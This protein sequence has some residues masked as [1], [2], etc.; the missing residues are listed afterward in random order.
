MQGKLFTQDFLR[1]G[2]QET[3]AWQRLDAGELAR[4]RARIAAIFGAFPADSQANEAVTETE[5]I[6]Q[7]LEALGWASLPQQTASGKGRQ[8]VPDV[9]LFVDAAAKQAALAERRD[10]PRYRRG[11]AIVECKRWQ[12]PLDRGDR[13]DPLDANAPSNQM[14]RYLSRAEV[15][16]ERA[17]Q[18]G[19]LT[20]GRYWRLYFQGARSRSEEFLELDLARLAGMKGLPADLL[21]LADQDAAHFLTVFYLLFG[22]AGFIPQPEDPENRAFLVIALAETRRWEARVSQDLGALVFER[23]FPRLVAAMAQHDPAASAPH[24]AEDYLDTVRRE[25][26]ILLYRLLFVLYAEDRNLLPVHDPRYHHYSLRVIRQKIAR[27]LDANAVFSA[28]AGRCYRALKDLFQIIGQGDAALGVPPYNGGPFDDR[29]HA[30]LER[31]TLPDAVVAELI[32]GLSRRPVGQERRWINY[33]DL[34]VQQLGSIYERLL[35][36]RVVG[37]GAGQIR[38]SPTI[39]A[40]KGSGSYYTHDDLVQLLIRQ[41]VGPLLAERAD[42]FEL[43]VEALARLRSPK[44]QRLR[45][46]QDHDPAAAILELKIC[47]PAMG[48][49]H[50][51]VSLVDY[52]ADQILERMADSTARVHW[53]DAAEPYVSPLARRIADIRERI[54]AS[55][56]A[57]GWTV[58]PAQLDDRHIV[59][60]MILKRVIFGVDK[61]P[62]AVEL[63]KVALWLHT[64]TVGA[65]LSF[66]DHHLR[67]G[68]ALY[69]ERI[70]KVLDELRAFGALF[71]NNELA[72]IAV[73]TA[74]M[75]QIADLTDVDIAE[76]QQSR[77]LFEQIDAELAP[78]RKL[79]DFWQAR[80]WLPAD[81]P[82]WRR[83]WAE[84]ASGRF[85]DVIDVVNAGSVVAGDSASD[86][87]GAIRELLRQTRELA[88][89]E[90]FLSWAIA[91]PTVWR[92][93]DSSQ[94]QGGFDA[95]IG[96]PPWDRMKLQEVEWFA[97][98]QPEI[99]HAVRAA[100]RKRLIGQLEKTGDG[101]WL[102]YQQA[103]NRAEIAARIA[104]DS[105]EYPLLSGG[106]LNLYALFVERAQSLV[107]AHGIVGLLTPSGIASDKGSSAFF[108]SIATTGRLAALLDFE[109]R[110]GFFPDVDSRFKFCALVFGGAK[111]TFP[112]TRCA[113][114]LHA[115]A[116]L[117]DP[118]R[119]FSL[120]AED[121]AAVNPNTGTAPIFRHRRDAEITR[122]IYGRCPVL[123]DRRTDPPRQVWPVRYLRMFDM[124]NDSHLFK[125]RDE[126]EAA[127]FYP[128]GVHRWRKAKEEYVPLYVGRM[129]HQYDH[130]AAGVEVNEASLHNP[131]LSSAVTLAEKRDISF[132]PF[133]QYWVPRDKVS[134]NYQRW[135]IGFRD[136]A[137]ATDIRTLIAAII[138][139]PST[140]NKL[141]LLLPLDSWHESYKDFAPLV[142]ANLNCYPLD[143][144][145]RQKVHSTNV[146]WYILE[147]IP[148]IP[149]EKFENS[150]GDQII[151][152]F[153]RAQVLRLS[154]TA[155]DLRPFAADLGYEGEPFV[156]DEDDRRHRLARL[157]ALF[158]HLYGLDRNDA[159]YILGQFPIVREQDEKQFGRYL[160]RDLILA[161]MNAIAA[162]D[163]ETMVEVR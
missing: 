94:P 24:S 63:A 4:F 95:I 105:G 43:Q 107:N 158:F 34:S 154:Y 11:V 120:S 44:P 29:A 32:D 153:I 16:S 108:K 119:S 53:A 25:A 124:T 100:D 18:W 118:Q 121:F 117:D 115:V 103:R 49:G 70:D 140:G 26:L 10:E 82:V 144:V 84:L 20:N 22:P 78:L 74:S 151:A 106:D 8:D 126:L 127:G 62:M 98:R 36:Y 15:A 52:L 80:R 58:D 7:V 56:Q 91:F 97:A 162:G 19:L 141:P 135:V 37:D 77:H 143:Y 59:R 93:L 132:A 145:L 79:L 72:R 86:E 81:H 87:A 111:R 6:F 69:G 150:I 1:E 88:E 89:Q 42:A 30:L 46:L 109:N 104:R 156:W 27:H 133:P 55:S 102:E 92:H 76:V 47:D 134:C 12:R 136:V 159:D 75:N 142:L 152:D 128:V 35:E 39:F 23:L 61:N 65:P 60:R 9:L 48:S 90:G 33:R 50:F 114:F 38:V 68:D 112:E 160:T 147:Q 138:P 64:F 21:D 110:K 2:I 101:L 67:A 161:Y 66:L 54:L 157:D 28:S 41:T 163:L 122:A 13:T 71:Q 130:R 139:F 3:D 40:R 85:G 31:L 17:I 51:L 125:R 73:A 14:L 99:A 148:L 57:Q 113:F 146:N 131:A 45:D 116:E 137:R 83:G 96:N 155:V 5:I 123:V 149:P 129:I